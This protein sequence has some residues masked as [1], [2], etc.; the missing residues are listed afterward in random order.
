MKSGNKVQYLLCI[1]ESMGI[2]F[3][4]DNVS[5]ADNLALF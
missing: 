5:T 1:V 2:F 3:C 4:V